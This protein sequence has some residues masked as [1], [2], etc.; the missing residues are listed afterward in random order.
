MLKF[1]AIDLMYDKL[2]VNIGVIMRDM[3]KL[4]EV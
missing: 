2:N 1:V 3:M 4:M